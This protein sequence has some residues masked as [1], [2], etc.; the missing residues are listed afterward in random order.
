MTWNARLLSIRH[1][2]GTGRLG[3]VTDK[4]VVDVRTA[5]AKLRIRAPLTL[6]KLLQE[7]NADALVKV[8][9][10]ARSSGT[11]LLDESGIA[12]GRLPLASVPVLF[13]KFDNTLAA[14]NAVIALPPKQI[15]FKFDYETE[16]LMVIGKRSRDVAEFPPIASVNEDQQHPGGVRGHADVDALGLGAAVALLYPIATE[17]G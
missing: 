16:L 6:D 17:S 15:A 11:A 4:G 13:N 12:H 8:V 14:H 7:G 3:A 9:E 1:A 10:R 5:A 2:N